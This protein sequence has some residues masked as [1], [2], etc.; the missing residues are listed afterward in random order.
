MA[1]E[2]L[3][4]C[5]IGSPD[6]DCPRS[7]ESDA[8]PAFDDGREL[9][10]R[11]ALGSLFE[12]GT[13]NGGTYMAEVDVLLPALVPPGVTGAEGPSAGVGDVTVGCAKATWAQIKPRLTA[14]TVTLRIIGAHHWLTLWVSYLDLVSTHV[15]W[16]YPSAVGLR[17]SWYLPLRVLPLVSP[18]PRS[19]PF[20]Y[21]WARHRLHHRCSISVLHRVCRE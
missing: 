12:L 14:N 6:P 7:N 11:P 15:D 18:R 4:P 9:D 16:L 5:T 1:I 21:R 13:P 8:L 19:R 20:R 10:G 3:L 2:P 17:S